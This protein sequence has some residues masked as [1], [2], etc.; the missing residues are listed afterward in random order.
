MKSIVGI[1]PSSKDAERAA[2]RLRR[3]KM[4]K[5][6]IELLTPE[7]SQTGLETKVP[8]QDAESQGIGRALGGV[9]VGAIA[10]AGASHLGAYIWG[11][12]AAHS[13]VGPLVAIGI[14]AAGALGVYA[15]IKIMGRFEEASSTGLPHDNLYLYK[16]ALEHNHSLV[17]ALAESDERADLVRKTL[18]EMGAES[19]DEPDG[20]WWIGLRSAE[21]EHFADPGIHNEGTF[22]QLGF[23]AALSPDFKGHSYD[24]VL[25]RLVERYGEEARTTDFRLGFER[26]RSY[27]DWES[28]A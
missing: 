6:E 25:D 17:V 8:T 19:I 2:T 7:M 20:D 4:A 10:L 12:Y 28:A 27:G 15:G 16:D 18:N 1:F 14:V 11:K 26:G 3:L 23:Q 5:E 13:F 24:E 9:I 21:N 22:S